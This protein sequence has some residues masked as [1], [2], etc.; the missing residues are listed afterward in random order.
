MV[1]KGFMKK[2]LKASSNEILCLFVKLFDNFWTTLRLGA[3]KEHTACLN[4]TADIQE[5]LTRL[6]QVFT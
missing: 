2:T 3:M 1:I 5:N 4:V 6:N